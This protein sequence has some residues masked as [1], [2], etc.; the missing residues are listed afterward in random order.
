MCRSW[1]VK[2]IARKTTQYFIFKVKQ[3]MY[4][5]FVVSVSRF[6][7]T[8][9]INNNNIGVLIKFSLTKIPQLGIFLLAILYLIVHR[10]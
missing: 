7:T 9:K 6:K 1:E 4:V 3:F 2:C 8:Y 5:V 10:F